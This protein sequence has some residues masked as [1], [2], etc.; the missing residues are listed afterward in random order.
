LSIF[1]THKLNI[2][3]IIK[4]LLPA[5]PCVLCGSMSRNGLWCD[6]CDAALPY[7]NAPHCPVCAL[8]TAQGEVCGRCQKKPPAFTGTITVYSYQFPVDKLIQAM[9]YREQ[10]ALSRIFAEKLAQR[11]DPGRLPDYL[12]PMPLHPAKLQSR[13]YNQAQLIAAPLA[14]LLNIPLLAHACR[15]LRDTPSQTSL[16][17]QARGRNVR[18]AFACDMNLS[19]KHIALVDDVMTTGASMNE[20]ASAVKKCGAGEISAWVVARTVRD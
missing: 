1:N 19:G 6:A 8:P 5:Q 4:Q 14:K 7:H 15:R 17:W 18:G 3:T 13:G 10:L 16:P 12:I 20:L 11:T 9:K 2:G